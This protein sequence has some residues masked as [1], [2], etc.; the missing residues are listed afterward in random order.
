MDLRRPRCVLCFCLETS[1]HRQERGSRVSA[2]S[3]DGGAAFQRV[4]A[5]AEISSGG[6]SSLAE[7]YKQGNF[8]NLGK[9]ACPT[10]EMHCREIEEKKKHPMGLET[11]LNIPEPSTGPKKVASHPEGSGTLLT[12]HHSWLK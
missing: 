7:L 11:S 4:W 1:G 5:P 10:K 9:Q 12:G 8:G 3:V 2:V 6:S